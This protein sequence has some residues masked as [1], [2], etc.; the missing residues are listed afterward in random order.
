MKSIDALVAC[1]DLAGY[2]KY[3]GS[4]SAEE[5]FQLLSG[6]YEYLGDIVAGA[7]GRVIKFMGDAALLLFPDSAVDAGMMA[8]LKLQNE[9]DRYLAGKGIPCRHHIRAH[10]GT[11]IEGDLGTRAEKRPDILGS[12]VNAVFLLKTGGFVITPE[13]FRKL[14]KESRQHFKKHTPPVSYIPLEQAHRD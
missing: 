14:N 3:A 10:F 7:N 8:L 9:G 12:A 2:A 6:Y 4:K 1:S 5:I 11:V 13:A